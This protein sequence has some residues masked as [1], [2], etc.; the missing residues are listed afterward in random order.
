V[1]GE[2][3]TT[4]AEHH[5]L[6][7]AA[8]RG[9][10]MATRRLVKLVLPIIQARL[11]RVLARRR[12]RSN[13]DVRQEIEDLAQ[14]VFVSL[15]ERDGRIL[16]A[17][18]PSRGLSLP[19]F[20][21]LIAEREAASILRSGRRSP[22]TEDATEDEE[23]A[24]GAGVAADDVEGAF[25]SR[26]QLLRLADRLREELSPLGLEMFQRLMVDEEGADAVCAATGMKAD[27]VYA[28]KSRLSKLAR[29]LA[30]EIAA[31]EPHV[32]AAKSDEKTTRAMSET[33]RLSRT[34]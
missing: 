20:C 26:D 18:D 34:E 21:G 29:K 3:N 4:E 25:V 8:L 23:L 31:S 28:W 17:W 14:E 6:V 30:I 22:W 32:K 15:F 12:T 11:G 19:S 1:S 9:D 16:R 2:S 5:T 33:S 13:R 7:E 10:A 27:A 24:K